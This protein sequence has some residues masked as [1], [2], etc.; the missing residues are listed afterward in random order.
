[1]SLREDILYNMLGMELAQIF[2]YGEV[3]GYRCA[4]V[5]YHKRSTCS[6]RSSPSDL[7]SDWGSGLRCQVLQKSR[8]ASSA[9]NRITQFLWGDLCSNAMSLLL[10]WLPSGSIGSPLLLNAVYNIGST[11]LMLLSVHLRARSLPSSSRKRVTR[12]ASS[13]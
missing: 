5:H 13:W 11:G 6:K 10:I 4:G 7:N 12:A 2:N 1:M 8:A 3:D 9:E